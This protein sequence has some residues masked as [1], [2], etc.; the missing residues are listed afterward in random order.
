MKRTKFLFSFMVLGVISSEWHVMSS[1]FFPKGL[2]VTAHIH[3]D[4]LRN[5]VKPWMDKIADG[6]PY[7]SQQD[8]APAHKAK[9]TQAWLLDSVPHHWSPDLR[10]PTFPTATPSTCCCGVIEAKTN[11]HAQ[12]TVDSLKAGVRAEFAAV[13][14]D[15]VTKACGSFRF[16]LEMVVPAGGGYIEKQCCSKQQCRNNV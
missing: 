16:R 11:K 6:R 4:V 10:L 8:S 14:R 5:V 12:N 2:G 1:F 3:Q 13:D 9:T 7:V 15:V